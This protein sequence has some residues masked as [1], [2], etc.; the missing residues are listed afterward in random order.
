MTAGITAISTRRNMGRKRVMQQSLGY[1]ERKIV[2][3]TGKQQVAANAGPG[4]G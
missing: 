4:V 2:H 1:F 3:G